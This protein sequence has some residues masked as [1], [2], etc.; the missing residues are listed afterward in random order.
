[1][2]WVQNILHSLVLLFLVSG[3]GYFSLTT[4]SLMCNLINFRTGAPIEAKGSAILNDPFDPLKPGELIVNF[5][6]Q[7]SFSK[8]L[9]EHEEFKIRA[10]FN[11]STSYLN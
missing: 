9:L 11:F 7:P 6:S 10:K 2:S 5:D 4:I 8:F 3:Y 1:M